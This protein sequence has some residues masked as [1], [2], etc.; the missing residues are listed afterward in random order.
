MMSHNFFRTLGA[1]AVL[2]C[3]TACAP[4]PTTDDTG[5][6]PPVILE[7]DNL[8]LTVAGGPGSAQW[9]DWQSAL[10]M[11]DPC[12]SPQYARKLASP[13]RPLQESSATQIQ[14]L[15]DAGMRVIVLTSRGPECRSQS[16]EQLHANGF[17]FEVNPWPPRDGYPAAFL[18]GAGS[19]PVIYEDGVFFTAGQHK[20]RM[21]KTLLD[22]SSEPLPTLV[23]MADH[24][25]SHL[26]EVMKT[27]SLTRT[28]VHAWRYTR[29]EGVAIPAEI[30]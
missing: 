8:L 5:P 1:L 14:R 13:M 6:P 19:R 28:K 10:K 2:V 15:Q 17:R 29:E 22:K 4:A 11:E 30:Q 9:N 20:G 21:L 12:S 23:V 3:G 24:S 16:F 18:P 27:F 26:N 25:Q 7:I